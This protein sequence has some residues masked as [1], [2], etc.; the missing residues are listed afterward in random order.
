MMLD[1]PLGPR[2]GA[3]LMAGNPQ[4]RVARDA[5]TFLTRSVFDAGMQLRPNFIA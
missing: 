5:G 1:A 3:A 4:R 2:S